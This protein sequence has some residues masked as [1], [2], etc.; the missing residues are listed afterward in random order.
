MLS[1]IFLSIKGIL[2]SCH[3]LIIKITLIINYM[4][5]KKEKQVFDIHSLPFLSDFYLTRRDIIGNKHHGFSS[6]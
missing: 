5:I 2:A 4:S 3:Q 6:E 1:T